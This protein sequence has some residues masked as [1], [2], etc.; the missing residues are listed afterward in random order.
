MA[1]VL[2]QL[3]SFLRVGPVPSHRKCEQFI[4]YT[5]KRLQKILANPCFE[6]RAYFFLSNS[7]LKIKN[8]MLF[9]KKY[10]IRERL[11]LLIRMG[12]LL[13]QVLVYYTP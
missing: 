2:S 5:V 12:T 13:R 10:Y 7:F 9:M 6:K 3:S 11:H 1:E 4:V 8:F